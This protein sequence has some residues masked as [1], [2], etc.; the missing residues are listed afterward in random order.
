VVGALF[1]IASA[2][3]LRSAAEPSAAARGIASRTIDSASRRRAA[4][5]PRQL[6]SLLNRVDALRDGASPPIRA[7]DVRAVLVPAA[8]YGATVVLQYL[9]TGPDHACARTLE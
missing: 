5:R 9:Q 2:I 3:A 4:D 1:V 6:D 7:A 8:T